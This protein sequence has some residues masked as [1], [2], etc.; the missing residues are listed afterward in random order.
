MFIAVIIVAIPITWFLWRSFGPI[1]AVT[2]SQ[3]FEN[4]KRAFFGQLDIA[5]RSHLMVLPSLPV[6]DVLHCGKWGRAGAITNLKKDLRFDFV[7]YD[8]R[9][10]RVCCAI[11]LIPYKTDANTRELRLLR[12]LCQATELP[13]LEYDMKPWRD[14]AELRKSIFANLGLVEQGTPVAEI[15]EEP[16]NDPACPKCQGPMTLRTLQ[17]GARA[18]QRWWV[19]NTFPS[20]KGARPEARPAARLEATPG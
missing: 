7:L 12:D 14:V 11:V 18:G 13:L 8:R 1:K 17:K 20:C 10:M 16:K 4:D 9:K 19:C 2:N 3:L 5:V 15:K 6:G